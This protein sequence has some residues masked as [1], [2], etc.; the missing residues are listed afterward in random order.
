MPLYRG[1]GRAIIIDI[2]ERRLVA[3]QVAADVLNSLHI[4]IARR[5]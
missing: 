1:R 3:W 4:R 2:G 5:Q